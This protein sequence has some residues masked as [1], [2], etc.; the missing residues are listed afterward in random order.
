[1]AIVNLGTKEAYELVDLAA[2]KAYLLSIK[3]NFKADPET[4]SIYGY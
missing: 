4:N 1:M 3:N 2:M